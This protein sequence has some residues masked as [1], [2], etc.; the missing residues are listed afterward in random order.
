MSFMSIRINRDKCISCGKCQKVC[1]GNLLYKDK[2]EKA[3]IR[4]PEECWGC[5]AC[6]KECSAEAIRYY[7]RIDIGGGDGY[8]YTSSE[9]DCLNW[10]IIDKDGKEKIIRINRKEA[11][12]Y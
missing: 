8:L 7:L 9:K 6:L 4:Y 2:C 12:K 11:N 5:A 10:H 3:V 1:P